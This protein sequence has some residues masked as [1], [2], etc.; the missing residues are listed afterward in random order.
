MQAV[1]HWANCKYDDIPYHSQG[2]SSLLTFPFKNTL[3]MK[4]YLSY[5]IWATGM[6]QRN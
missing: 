5:W 3:Y 1:K 4:L 6:E 2:K